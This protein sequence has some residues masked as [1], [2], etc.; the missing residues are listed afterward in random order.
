M[1]RRVQTIQQGTVHGGLALETL[2]RLAQLVT[3][4]LADFR[5]T[6]AAAYLQHQEDSVFVDTSICMTRCVRIVSE[7]EGRSGGHTSRSFGVAMQRAHQVSVKPN[8]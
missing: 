7:Q 6:T 2:T 8:T 1:L 5:S 3:A 4:G